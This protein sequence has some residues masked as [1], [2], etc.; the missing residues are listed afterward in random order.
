MLDLYQLNDH[1]KLY[2]HTKRSLDLYQLSLI[3]FLRINL[4]L[5]FLRYRYLRV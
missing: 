5:Y 1:T 2:D 3:D 4:S